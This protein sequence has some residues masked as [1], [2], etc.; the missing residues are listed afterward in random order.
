MGYPLNIRTNP[1]YFDTSTAPWHV[2]AKPMIDTSSE[3]IMEDGEE[4][5][6]LMLSNDRLLDICG[7][8][9]EMCSTDIGLE[10]TRITVISINNGIVYDTLVK[11]SRPIRDYH[12]TFSGITEIALDQVNSFTHSFTH[13]LTHLLIH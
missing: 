7:I 9:C 6:E 10:L 2:P 13:S 1:K 3:I 8:D 12:T 5:D 4:T 11:P